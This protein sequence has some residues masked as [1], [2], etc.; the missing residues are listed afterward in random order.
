M[1]THLYILTGASRGLGAAIARQL[2][3]P[4][5]TLLCLSRATSPALDEFASERGVRVEQWSVDLADPPAAAARLETWLRAEGGAFDA[6]T[7]I[8][9]AGVLA[10]AGALDAAG[11]ATISSALRVGLEAPMLLAAAFLRATADRSG[12]RRI[13]NVSS[14]L[15]RRAMAGQTTYCA[16]KAG[17]DH[18][19]RALALDEALKPNGARVCSLAPGVIDTDMQQQLRSADDPG[20]PDRRNFVYLKDAGQLTS[21]ENAAARV[22]AYLARPDFG[23]QAVADVR[24]A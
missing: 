8:N 7:L 17:L 1:S 4:A 20:F 11:D 16:A 10:P 14:G 12:A 21:P 24:D 19:T 2:V 5:H 13:L 15:G 3:D 23:S 6:A 9:N 22:L 18:F